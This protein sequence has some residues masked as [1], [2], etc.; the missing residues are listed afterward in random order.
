MTTKLHPDETQDPFWGGAIHVI[1]KKRGYRFSVDAVLLASFV[2]PEPDGVCLD[3]GTGSGIIPLL[4]LRSSRCRRAVGLEI[5]EDLADMASRNAVL[6]GFHN[7]LQIVRGDIKA[8]EGLFLP[9]SFDLA[10]SNPPY[11]ERS[12][13]HRSP[14]KEKEIARHEVLVNL[15]DTVRAG[16]SSLGPGGAFYMIHLP[17]RLEEIREHLH[18]YECSCSVLRYALP[19][20]NEPPGLVLIKA[21]R[22]VAG[23]PAVTLDPITMHDREGRYT[24][25]MERILRPDLFGTLG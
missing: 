18:T 19:R 2:E 14:V 22:G 11:R 1:Q 23:A 24:P 7:R 3:L 15:E 6:N 5:Q 10:V 17:E 12:T 9:G 16:A 20:E 21:V 13:G 4:L 25:E 8:A